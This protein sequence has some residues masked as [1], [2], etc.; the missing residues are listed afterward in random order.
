MPGP[1]MREEWKARPCIELRESEEL[2]A[3]IP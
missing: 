3:H 1:M 2:A